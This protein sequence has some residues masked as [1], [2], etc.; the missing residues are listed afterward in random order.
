MDLSETFVLHDS[1]LIATV[2]LKDAAK[3]GKVSSKLLNE[4]AQSTTRI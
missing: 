4:T 3:V 2:S 1:V